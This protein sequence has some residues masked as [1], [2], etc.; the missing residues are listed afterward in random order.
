MKLLITQMYLEHRLSNYNCILDLTAGFNGLGNDTER[1]GEKQ[2]F[3]DFVRI[4]LEIWW[5]MQNIWSILYLG[6]CSSAVYSIVL[7]WKNWTR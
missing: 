2:L 6:C 4:I 3:S 5:Y 1:R 7:N